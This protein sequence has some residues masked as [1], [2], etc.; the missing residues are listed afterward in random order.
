GE[1]TFETAY[2]YAKIASDATGV[3]AALILAILDQESALGK[4]VGRCTLVDMTTGQ[5][6][7][8]TSGTV[9]KNGIHPTRDLPK[10]ISIVT[11]LGK[12]PMSTTVSCPVAG[13]A[14]YGGAMGPAQFIP[15]TW[16]AYEDSIKKAS[17]AKVA[18]PWNNQDAFIATALYLKDAGAASNETMAAA[19]YYCGGN[20]NRYVCTSVYGKQ[21]IARANG[22]ADDIAVLNEQTASR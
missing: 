21:V 7:S 2:R 11:K 19:K 3:R 8:I 20:W 13:V 4:N 9:F 1:M 17:G 18:D 6:K 10:F 12:D 16:D 22:F 14:G 15:S 5:T